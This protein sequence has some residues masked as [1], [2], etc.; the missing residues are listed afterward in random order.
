MC[1]QRESQMMSVISDSFSEL[2]SVSFCCELFTSGRTWPLQVQIFR[3][4]TNA[5]C[6]TQALNHAPSELLMDANSIEDLCSFL[7]KSDAFNEERWSWIELSRGP[8]IV[9]IHLSCAKVQAVWSKSLFLKAEN[10]ANTRNQFHATLQGGLGLGKRFMELKKFLRS[11]QS[12]L[13]KKTL[14]FASS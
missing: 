1:T 8:Q 3:W 10:V 6:S 13:E 12:S 4:K 2:S 11:W 5:F 9:L 7:K 14:F